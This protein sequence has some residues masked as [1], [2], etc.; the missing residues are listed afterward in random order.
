[1]GH[2]FQGRYKACVIEK[3]GYL[4]E[5]A[6]YIA[7]NPVRAVII[8]H[9]RD[10]KW[11]SYN[12]T[13]E[14]EK[15]PAWLHTDWI[16]EFFGEDKQQSQKSYQTFITQGIKNTDPQIEL[17]HGFILGS[18]QFIDWIWETQTN[19]SEEQKE[20]PREQRIVGRPTLKDLFQGVKIKDERNNTIKLARF[21]C[22]YSVV[23]IA[24]HL[25]MHPSVVGRISKDRYN[26]KKVISP[27]SLIKLRRTGKT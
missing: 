27:P 16:L 15:G 6:R 1:V 3:E 17:K 10:W 24:K 22:G 5:V 11:S 25:K 14:K 21:R 20:H 12:T 13:T 18:P 9:P 23:E 4:M 26:N 19:G 7:L 2:L 8:D